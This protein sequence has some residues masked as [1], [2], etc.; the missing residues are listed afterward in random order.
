MKYRYEFYVVNGKDFFVE[1]DMDISP[2]RFLTDK[3]TFSNPDGSF[4]Q[5]NLKEVIRIEKI[6]R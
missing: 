4:I 6:I 1:T 2:D 3:I 5:I